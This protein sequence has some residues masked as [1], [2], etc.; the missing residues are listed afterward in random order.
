MADRR[1]RI[2]QDHTRCATARCRVVTLTLVVFASLL[3]TAC[4]SGP[5]KQRSVIFLR[6][7][8]DFTTV[9]DATQDV[10]EEQF[11]P[12]VPDVTSRTITSGYRYDDDSA[13]SIRWHAVAHIAP[14]ERNWG[15]HVTTV[16]ERLR[17]KG[18]T[19][20]GIDDKTSQWLV[21]R[22]DAR[23]RE[24]AGE[25]PTIEIPSTARA[26]AATPPPDSR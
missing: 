15:V 24:K 25:P 20:I 13:G 6:Q 1:N 11:A 22:V 16:A 8:L 26:G 19:R 18:W 3:L 7:D 12:G 23:V 5:P 14:Y 17:G 2:E 21:R 9:W 4:A 10:L